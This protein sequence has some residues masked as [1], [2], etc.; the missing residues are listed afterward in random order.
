MK[1]SSILLLA[2]IGVGSAQP[3]LQ[4]AKLETVAVTGAL[5][6]RV[7]DLAARQNDPVWIGYA[8]PIVAGRHSQC[9][10]SSIDGNSYYGCG[11]E[12]SGSNMTAS[13]QGT[14]VV[15][16][17]SPK[18]VYIL[19]R[20][21]NKNVERIRTY[22]SDCDLDAGGTSFIWLTGVKP[23]ESVALLDSYVKNTAD[24]AS[25][26]DR[27]R[28]GAVGALSLTGDASATAVLEEYLAPGQP[29]NLRRRV[30]RAMGW[31]GRRG[32]EVLSRMV[33]EEKDE[34][35]RDAAIR[36][37]GN[38]SEPEA[39]QLL[40]TLARADT[41][42]RVRGEALVIL[43]QRTGV[44]A[45]PVIQA[46]LAANEDREVKRRALS[47][48]EQLPREEAVPLMI[49]LVKTSTDPDLRKR[50]LQWLSRSHDSRASTFFEQVLTK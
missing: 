43:A 4:N 26:R 30:A 50:A 40:T 29:E 17:E 11:L 10:Y 47:A 44:K 41:N 28:E 22:T 36:G 6:D 24:T 35:V 38:N 21:E 34:N 23:A 45:I 2:A 32:Y 9:C 16:L 18:E 13:G 25:E 1:M 31:R 20:A 7:K 15:H 27:L 42:P 48:L 12:S 14:P 46:A 33:K 8:M 19:F 5:A 39:M 37:L 3:R 49:N